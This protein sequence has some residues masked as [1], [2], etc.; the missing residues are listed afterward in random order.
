[1]QFLKDGVQ[2]VAARLFIIVL[3]FMPTGILFS[4]FCSYIGL[5]VCN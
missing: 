3:A 1:M 5:F 4:F 2:T